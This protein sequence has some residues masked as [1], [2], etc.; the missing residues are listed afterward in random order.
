[1]ID[2]LPALKVYPDTCKGR[3]A[4]MRVCPTH[5]IRVRKRKVSI[6]PELCIDCGDCIVACPE[7][8]IQA[9]TDSKESLKKFKFKV[10]IV[11]PVLYGQFSRS[12]SPTDIGEGLKAIGFDAVFNLSLETELYTRALKDYMDEF[13]GPYPVISSICPVIIRLLQVSYPAMVKQI[14]PLQPPRE[15]AGRAAKRYYIKKLGI[16]ERDIGAIYI[17]PCLAKMASI[18]SPAEGVKSHLDMALGVKDIYNSLLLA[19]TR[20]KRAAKDERV[21]LTEGESRSLL[22]LKFPVTGSLAHALNAPHRI[23]VAQLPNIVKVIE[24]IEKGKIKDIEFLECHACSGGC[25]GGPLTV[26]DQ[27]VARSKLELITNIADED[28]QRSEELI[29]KY[30]VNGDYFIEQPFRPRPIESQGTISIIE[31]IAEVKVLEGFVNELPGFDC[32]LCGSPTCEGFA[33]DVARRE[34]EPSECVMLNPER[35][36]TLRDQYEIFNLHEN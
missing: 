13:K 33:L 30:Y 28:A 14:V 27:F 12:I 6:K 21:V 24:D 36:K 32:G 18:K 5:A 8:A 2:T 22:Y 16:P 11:S 29:D 7:G 34:V 20:K 17:T 26:D 9:R 4:C 35:I 10:A 19:I 1:M 31:R 23:V 3:L 15:L 25:L